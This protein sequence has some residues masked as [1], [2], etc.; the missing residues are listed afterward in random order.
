MSEAS[1]TY[2]GGT[3]NQAFMPRTP[4]EQGWSLS[5]VGGGGFQGVRLSGYGT[6]ASC[7]PA[8]TI[9]HFLY[10]RT[11]NPPGKHGVCDRVAVGV[12]HVR[13]VGYPQDDTLCRGFDV[14]PSGRGDSAQIIFDCNRI[15]AAMERFELK[16]EYLRERCRNAG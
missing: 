9:M 14:L 3:R 7:Y 6:Q 16:T 2:E 11:S 8:R 10:A 12:A 13:A 4:D 5:S 15:Y 1:L